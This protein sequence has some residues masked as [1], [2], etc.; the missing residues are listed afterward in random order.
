MHWS[1]TEKA[2]IPFQSTISGEF[3]FGLLMEMLMMLKFATIIKTRG[4]DEYS[5]YG[6]EA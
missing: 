5:K 4:T 1:V 3:A 6:Y 2:N